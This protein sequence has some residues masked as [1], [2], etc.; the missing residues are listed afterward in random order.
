[1]GMGTTSDIPE[2]LPTFKAEK[3]EYIKREKNYIEFAKLE[4]FLVEIKWEE[5][6]LRKFGTGE[7]SDD[8]KK[9][10]KMCNHLRLPSVG[11]ARISTT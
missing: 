8:T 1:M 10:Q 7:C 11:G 4:A 2:R 6:Q 3:L 9:V 5:D